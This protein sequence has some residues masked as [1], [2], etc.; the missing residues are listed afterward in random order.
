MHIRPSYL[1][2]NYACDQSLKCSLNK[3]WH[4]ILLFAADIYFSC[5]S[6]DTVTYCIW[7]FSI[8]SVCVDALWQCAVLTV[9]CWFLSFCMSQSHPS[10]SRAGLSTH[11]SYQPD[12]DG[13]MLPLCLAGRSFEET[14]QKWQQW[15]GRHAYRRTPDPNF[16][17]SQECTY[18]IKHIYTSTFMSTRT[19]FGYH[20]QI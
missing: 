5:S 20:K 14:Q 4:Y 18:M 19:Q 15:W 11:A 9:T 2:L 17:E 7:S 13:H 10:I 3:Q 16:K 6:L 8:Q 12:F 1:S